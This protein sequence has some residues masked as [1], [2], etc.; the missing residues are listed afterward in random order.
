MEEPT[1]V[2]LT[3]FKDRPEKFPFPE[4][5]KESVSSLEDQAGDMQQDDPELK[6]AA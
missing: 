1:W 4:D 5:I 3:D 2:D 6:K